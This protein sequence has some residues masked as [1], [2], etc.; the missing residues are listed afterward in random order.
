MSGFTHLHTVSGFSL[1]Y[2]A[3]TRNGWPNAPSTAA[4]TPSP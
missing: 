1:R 2:G 3:S 4:W